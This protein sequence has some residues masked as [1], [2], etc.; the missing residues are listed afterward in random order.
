[1]VL[2]GVMDDDVVY[3]L[4]ALEVGHQKFSLGRVNGVEQRGFPAAL[5]KIGVVARAVRK[6][7]EGIKESP[8]PVDSAYPENAFGYL[9]RFHNKA[10]YD[11]HVLKPPLPRWEGIEG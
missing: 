6:G 9:S 4:D 2:L 5:Y 10:P 11:S 8:V 1:M 3:L 7:Y